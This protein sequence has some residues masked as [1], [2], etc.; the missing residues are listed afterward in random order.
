MKYEQLQ[1]SQCWVRLPHGILER[2]TA[3]EARQNKEGLIA[4][5]YE[6][7]TREEAP[8]PAKDLHDFATWFDVVSFVQEA[9]K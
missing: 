8:S 2:A 7:G 3:T 1:G 4:L 6:D 9:Q 5:I